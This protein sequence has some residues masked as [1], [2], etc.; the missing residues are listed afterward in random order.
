VSLVEGITL[1][2]AVPIQTVR[3][4]PTSHKKYEAVL[5]IDP[6]LQYW[7]EP[8]SDKTL[9]TVQGLILQ[10]DGLDCG[11]RLRRSARHYRKAL[12]SNSDLA[13]FQHAYMG[14]E[15]LEKPLAETMNMTPGVEEAEG[16]CENCDAKYVKRRTALVGVRAYVR[17]DKHSETSSPE[18]RQEW[19]RINDLRHNLFHSLDDSNNL[20]QEAND[21]GPASIHYLHDAI[22]CLSHAHDLESQGFKV[23]RKMR[24]PVLMARVTDS[25]IG[26]LKEWKPLMQVRYFRW[27]S[28]PCHGYVPEIGIN[29]ESH[30]NVEG[31]FFWI[32]GPLSEA[33][34]DKLE[35]MKVEAG[36]L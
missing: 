12:G 4:D 25:E 3:I 27:V 26:P 30:G 9:K 34:E 21:I 5:F 11:N 20:E 23:V 14:L 18:R 31:A 22:C 10:W 6:T 29:N 35:P 33:S 19:K 36:D 15:T 13:T 17:G 7:P 1:E 32:D 24:R 16:T 28:D 8:I 2:E